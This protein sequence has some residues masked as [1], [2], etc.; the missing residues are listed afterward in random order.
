MFTCKG[1]REVARLVGEEG[2]DRTGKGG[3]DKSTAVTKIGGRR[4][5]MDEEERHIQRQ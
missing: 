1:C 3:Q 5:R 4:D 2:V